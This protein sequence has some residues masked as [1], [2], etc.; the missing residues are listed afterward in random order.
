MEFKPYNAILFDLDGTLLPMQQEEF[1]AAYFHALATA[2]A[3]FGIPPGALTA[4]VWQ[5]TAAMVQNDGRR[6]NEEVFWARFAADCQVDAAAMRPTVDAFYTGGFDA[7]R[8]ATQPNPLAARAVALAHQKAP[9][10]AL[11]TNPL[12]PLC[13]QATR[14]RWVGLTPADFDLVTSYESDCYCKPN[15]A[16]YRSVC[17]RLGVDPATC[18][19]IGNDEGEDMHAATAAGL[20]CYWVTDCAIPCQNHPWQGNRGTFADLIAFL[21]NL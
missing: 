8:T 20:A 2:L 17:Q 14:M 13:G 10:V 19:M 15:P 6:T 1:T 5:G 18:L 7:A 16:Y 11:A 9:L 12:F 3:P 4:G 21:E